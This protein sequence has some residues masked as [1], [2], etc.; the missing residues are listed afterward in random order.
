[1]ANGAAKNWEGGC[2][3]KGGGGVGEWAGKGGGGRCGVIG[4]Q[5]GRCGALDGVRRSEW[6]GARQPKSA[7]S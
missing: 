1:M 5:G 2:G 6:G 4:G 7:R 3:G